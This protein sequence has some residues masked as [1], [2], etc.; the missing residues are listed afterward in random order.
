MTGET[1]S[2]CRLPS[3]GIIV[4]IIAPLL[5]PVGASTMKVPEQ[6]LP[7]PIVDPLRLSAG[8]YYDEALLDV[9]Y[10]ETATGLTD[11]P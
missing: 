11:T 9:A 7:E 6:S 5:L 10:V 8:V 3:C 1:E 4:A 2:N